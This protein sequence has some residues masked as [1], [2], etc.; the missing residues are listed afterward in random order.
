MWLHEKCVRSL[1][2]A[3]R[4]LYICTTHISDLPSPRQGCNELLTSQLISHPPVPVWFGDPLSLG[5]LWDALADASGSRPPTP[6]FCSQSGHSVRFTVRWTSQCGT[7]LR[8]ESKCLQ[9]IPV[10][11]RLSYLH[12]SQSVTRSPVLTPFSQCHSLLPLRSPVEDALI[13]PTGCPVWRPS[14]SCICWIS[15]WRS[16]IL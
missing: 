5:V 8:L 12:D 1:P 13:K 15:I 9:C 2:S 11:C 3:R 16:R 7:L 14:S 10:P 6:P 4:E